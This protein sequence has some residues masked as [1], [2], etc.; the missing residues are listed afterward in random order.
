MCTIFN[1][2]ISIPVFHARFR[3][4]LLFRL[5]F[6]LVLY[7]KLCNTPNA[8]KKIPF[9]YCRFGGYLDAEAVVVVVVVDVTFSTLYIFFFHSFV[10][11]NK[12]TIL[13]GE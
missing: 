11:V 7:S 5:M 3:L 6:V 12:S 10:L 1:T 9:S 8:S 4:S 2:A 13:P